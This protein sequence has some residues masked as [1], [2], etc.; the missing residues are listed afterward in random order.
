MPTPPQTL[1]LGVGNPLRRD[2]AAGWWLASRLEVLAI[3]CVDIRCVQ[4]L[5]V[6]MAETWG[7]YDRV[8][9]LDAAVSGGAGLHRLPP[10]EATTPAPSHALSPG[11][12]Q[13]LSQTLFDHTPE[14]WVCAIPATDFSFGP[15]PSPAVQAA[16]DVAL[17][18]LRDLLQPRTSTIQ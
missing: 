18:Q 13:A 4:Q 6:E 5:Q 12:V 10:A 11:A 16:L 17:S 7:H 14:V 9:V 15:D 1:V 2:D 8:V 3:P